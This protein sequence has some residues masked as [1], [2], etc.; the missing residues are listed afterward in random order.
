MKILVA[1]KRALD[2]SVKARIA[3]DG[4]SIDM[5]GAKLAMNP[6][7]EIALEEAIRIKESS[8]PARRTEVVAVS[9]SPLQAHHDILRIAIALGAD[10][11]M[12]VDTTG[13]SSELS[14]L[15]VTEILGLG[16][17]DP[18]PLTIARL[19]HQ[20]AKKEV[21]DLI[22]CGKQSIDT[23]FSQTASMIASLLNCN[24]ATAVSKVS[25]EI[26]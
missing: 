10:R 5:I 26:Y 7:C 12:C 21:P 18:Q 3:A 8:L 25:S 6:F 16:V 20:I 22:L 4:R 15:D 13:E 11:A 14:S 19:I 17:D 24:Q 9:C 23:D 2:S 1:I